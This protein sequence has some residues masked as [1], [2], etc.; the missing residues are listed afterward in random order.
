MATCAR[1]AFTRSRVPWRSCG[2]DPDSPYLTLATSDFTSPSF[3][4]RVAC[5]VRIFC[6]SWL[7]FISSHLPGLPGPEQLHQVAGALLIADLLL[8][9]LLLLVEGGRGHVAQDADRQ[10]ILQLR[11]G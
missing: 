7:G 3:T 6:R 11:H 10:R 4:R 1:K 5:S 8:Q 9:L 2:S